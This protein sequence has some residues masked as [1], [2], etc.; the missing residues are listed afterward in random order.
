MRFHGA[1][2]ELTYSQVLETRGYHSLAANR[3]LGY[4]LVV[5]CEITNYFLHLG[6]E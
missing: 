1:R 2:W 3:K 4:Q 6:L 5:C